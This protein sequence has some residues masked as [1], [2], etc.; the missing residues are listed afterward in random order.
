MQTLQESLS[1]LAKNL[2]FTPKW[3]NLNSL[4]RIEL[5]VLGGFVIVV[6]ELILK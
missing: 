5:E 4:L 3:V 2:I 6:F 1:A